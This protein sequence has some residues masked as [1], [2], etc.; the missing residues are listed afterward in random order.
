MPAGQPITRT[1]KRTKAKPEGRG[2][3]VRKSPDTSTMAAAA[4]VSPD[5]PLTEKQRLFAKHYAAGDSIPNAMAR[6]GYSTAQYSLGYRMIKMPN[7][8][9]VIDEERRLFEQQNEMTRRKV[10]DMLL[11]SYDFAKLAA[12]PA[13]MVSAAREIGRMC[14][15]YEPRK[16]QVDVNVQGSIAMGRMNA[17]SDADLLKI[18]ESGAAPALLEGPE[19]AVGDDFDEE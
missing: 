7:V 12:E 18:I 10:M 16:V 1:P 19:T 6:A 5:K 3:A 4:S 9:R 17:L 15:Y 14:G 8:I 2:T 11:E 13:S